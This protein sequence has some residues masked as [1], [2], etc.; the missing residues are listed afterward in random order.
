[1]NFDAQAKGQR[2]SGRRF[3]L[4]AFLLLIPGGIDAQTQAKELR[5]L[6]LGNSYTYFNNLPAVLEKIAGAV[7]GGPAIHAEK[8][9]EGGATLQTLYNGGGALA[10]IRRG[11]WD[12][13]VLQEQSTLGHTPPVGGVPQIKEPSQFFEYARKFDA[14][15]RKSGAKALFFATWARE[16]FPEHQRRLDDAY[17]RIARELDAGLAPVGLAWTLARIE[18][19]GIR[20]H[21]PD[22]SHPTGA[23][24]YL[25]A[26]VFYQ[27]LAD[28]VAF[29]APNRIIGP[30]GE[31][32]KETL[33]I[34]L[35]WSEAKTLQMLAARAVAQEPLRP[36]RKQ[37]GQG[38]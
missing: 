17:T 27:V 38:Q 5:V 32:G 3:L 12:Y 20:L 29:D 9:V 15:I 33:L 14:E 28:K 26:L 8:V 2:S 19:P 36:Q 13:V 4:A 31:T 10:A 7:K 37:T 16:D 23:G 11:G 21:L 22:R 34:S 6:F 30:D 24:T 18:A 35:T 25:A 1:M